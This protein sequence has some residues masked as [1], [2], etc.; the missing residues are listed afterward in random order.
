MG[1]FNEA[2]KTLVEVGGAMDEF[3]DLSHRRDLII[4]QARLRLAIGDAEEAARHARRALV[5]AEEEKNLGAE[6]KALGILI[7]CTD[8]EAFYHKNLE[9]AKKQN[10]Q[11][12]SLIATMNRAGRL[13]GNNEIDKA[14][15]LIEESLGQLEGI[16]SHIEL[17]RML[18]IAAE[19]ML[20]IG[21]AQ[22][23]KEYMER[24]ATM[25][26][27]G[28]Q[29]LDLART[30]LLAGKIAYMNK[31][32][33]ECFGFYREALNIHKAI[34]AQIDDARDRMIYQRQPSIGFLVTQ[35]KELGNVMT[36]N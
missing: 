17:S 22:K 16:K 21:K 34:V 13:M 9:I 2:Q 18:N 5:E 35:I 4:E 30:H 26:R 27:Q 11:R 32:Y 10:L 20:K 8:S 15:P 24:S 33:Q 31:D 36:K 25:A 28:G 29:Q 14:S 7:R 3:E 23:A 1:R 19:Y 6:L 12:E